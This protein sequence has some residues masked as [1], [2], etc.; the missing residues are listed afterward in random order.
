MRIEEILLEG[1]T[2]EAAQVVAEDGNKQREP[3]N[4]VGR[5]MHGKMRL[6]FTWIQSLV[7]TTTGCGEQGFP[8]AQPYLS[9]TPAG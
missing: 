1:E 2:G 3:N 9:H 8:S 6:Y 4:V 5:R 7:H